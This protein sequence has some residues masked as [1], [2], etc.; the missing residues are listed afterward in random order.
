MEVLNLICFNCIHFCE[1]NN[2]G[3]LSGCRAFPDGIPDSVMF[4]N[5][6]NKPLKPYE[7]KEDISSLDPPLEGQKGDYV[8]TPIKK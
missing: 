5:E 7:P 4:V 1:N 6:H 2:D 3:L 8:Y